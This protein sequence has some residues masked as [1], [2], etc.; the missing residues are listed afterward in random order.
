MEILGFEK[1]NLNILSEEEIL[2]KAEEVYNNKKSKFKGYDLIALKETY[3]KLVKEPLP[4][5]LFR[6]NELFNFSLNFIGCEITEEAFMQRLECLPPCPFKTDVYSGYIVPECIT[7]DR[8]EHIFKHDNRYFC[9]IMP[10]QN[11]AIMRWF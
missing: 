9:V 2:R 5:K 3:N 7:E 10:M 4:Y 8:Y 1:Q 6:L 11:K